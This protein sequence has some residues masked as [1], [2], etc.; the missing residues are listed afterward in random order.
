MVTTA[1]TADIIHFNTDPET[2]V[3]GN[4][5]WNV[6]ESTLDLSL[7]NNV[8]LQVGEEQVINVKASEAILNGKL[9]MHLEL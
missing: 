1:L 9:F 4:L 3:A 7:D 5:S 2:S 6:D 8:V